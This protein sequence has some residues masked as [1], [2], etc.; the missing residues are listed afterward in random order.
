MK[1]MALP[2][3]AIVAKRTSDQT[4]CV[5]TKLTLTMTHLLQHLDVLDSL[6]MLHTWDVI[7]IE[8]G[9]GHSRMKF[10]EGLIAQKDV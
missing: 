9:G 5:P 4:E 10:M 8:T 7:R 6:T 3:A 2:L 1:N